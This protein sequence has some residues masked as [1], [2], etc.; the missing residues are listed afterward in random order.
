MVERQNMSASLP[1]HEQGMLKA[2]F[3]RGEAAVNLNEI[4]TRLSSRKSY[5][6]QPLEQELIQRGWLDPERKRKR[7]VMVTLG[8]VGLFLGTVLFVSALTISGMFLEINQTLVLIT[9]AIAGLGGGMFVLSLVLTVY[10]GI[11]SLLTPAG[12]EQKIRWKG[13]RAYLEQVSRGRE[14]AIRPDTFER[15][16]AFAAAFGLG[17]TWAKTFQK[18]GGVPLPVWFQALPGSN[19]DFGSVVA[20]MSSADTSVSSAGADGSGGASGGGSSGAG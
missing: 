4:V 11:Y 16:L 14:P 6:Y 15:Y 12:E 3:K 19:A 7:T 5:F 8:L 13:F 1:P 2:L 9:A 17:E 10:S 20:V 18:L